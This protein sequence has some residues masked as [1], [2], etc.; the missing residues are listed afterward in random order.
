MKLLY[1]L[2]LL[3]TLTT[4]AQSTTFGI[5]AAINLAQ[6]EGIEL[7]G[8]YKNTP[9]ISYGGGLFLNQKLTG[10]SNLQVEVLY[11]EQGTDLD[12]YD[13][14]GMT[15]QLN[16]VA[17]PL[18][19][20]FT[21]KNEGQFHILLGAR[22]AILVN[23]KLKITEDDDEMNISTESYFSDNGLDIKVNEFD[24]ALSGGIGIGKPDAAMLNITYSQGII[25]VF[26]GAD[27]TDNVKNILLQV[28]FCF[29]FN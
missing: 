1:V 7:I 22:P 25:N 5:K 14:P 24:F 4:S 3:V 20:R 27:A 17:T 16:Y 18:Y 26:E 6:F 23:S 12:S 13:F 11:S 10:H 2:L 21:F 28:G 9:R 19:Y 8:D 29:A 15:Y